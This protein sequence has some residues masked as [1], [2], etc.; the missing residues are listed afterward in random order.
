MLFQKHQSHQN[1]KPAVDGQ[2][3]LVFPFL[4]NRLTGSPHFTKHLCKQ[5][6]IR[7]RD[8]DIEFISFY[9]SDGSADALQQ[10]GV[11]CSDKPVFY[12]CSMG[13]YNQLV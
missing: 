10:Q 3:T 8:F 13:V 11:V 9:N 7:R 4:S 12:G 5:Q 2:M 1:V 6:I